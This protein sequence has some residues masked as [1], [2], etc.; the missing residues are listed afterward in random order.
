MRACS[1]ITLLGSAFANTANYIRTFDKRD[2]DGGAMVV[3]GCREK[4]QSHVE[5]STTGV[6][7]AIEE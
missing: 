5:S 1:N 2:C 3:H 7:V 6:I 4:Y